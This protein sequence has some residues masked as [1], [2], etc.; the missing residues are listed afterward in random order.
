M[1]TNN[2]EILQIAVPSIV[3]NITVPLLGLI[4]AAIVGHLGA[5]SYIGA[6]AVGGMLFNIIYWIFGFLR[7]GTSGM[8]SQA[9]GQKDQAESMRILARSISVG[10]LIAFVFYQRSTQTKRFLSLLF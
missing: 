7:M 5:T 3:S 2:R 6:I 8:T 4:D 1:N 10:M 9:Y